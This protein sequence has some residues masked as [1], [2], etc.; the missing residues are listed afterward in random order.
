MYVSE[1]GTRHAAPDAVVK[2]FSWAITVGTVAPVR[3]VT[4]PELPSIIVAPAFDG[5]VVLWR[6]ASD[7]H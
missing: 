3:S 4:E 6:E 2:Y 1:V 7:H 5:R